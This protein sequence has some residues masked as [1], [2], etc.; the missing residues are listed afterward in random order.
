MPTR[1]KLTSYLL[2]LAAI[3]LQAIY[4]EGDKIPDYSFQ[5]TNL[6]NGQVTVYNRTLHEII[7][8]GKV[9]WVSFFSTS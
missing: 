9:A 3:S 5:D 2:L 8:Q 6:D 4:V 1:Q 7:D